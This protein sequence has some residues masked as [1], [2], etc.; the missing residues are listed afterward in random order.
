MVSP[1]IELG[2]QKRRWIP[3]MEFE[4]SVLLVHVISE[5]FRDPRS[6]ILL[7]SNRLDWGMDFKDLLK[8]CVE[9]THFIVNIIK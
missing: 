1:G 3:T 6:W 2:P 5:G 8:E 9:N 7:Y 4:E